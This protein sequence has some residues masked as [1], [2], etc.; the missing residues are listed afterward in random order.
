MVSGS[1]L[2]FIILG[3]VKDHPECLKVLL[4][5]SH[6]IFTPYEDYIQNCKSGIL[7]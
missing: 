6:R 3:R 7:I 2:R 1:G 5:F 4:I